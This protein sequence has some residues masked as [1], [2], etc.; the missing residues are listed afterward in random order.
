MKLKAEN[1]V[2]NIPTHTICKSFF[3]VFLLFRKL[4]LC[5]LNNLVYFSK[6]L[7]IESFLKAIK[8]KLRFLKNYLLSIE[9]FLLL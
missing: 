5:K 4:N 9:A 7:L 8:K 1:Y 3:F 2:D 6:C